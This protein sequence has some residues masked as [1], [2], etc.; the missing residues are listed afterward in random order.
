MPYGKVKQMLSALS[1]S[2]HRAL[3]IF[4]TVYL[5]FTVALAMVICISSFFLVRMGI[6]FFRFRGRHPVLCPETGKTAVIRIDA[7]HAAVSSLLADPELRVSDARF[8]PSARAAIKRV[9][10]S[11]ESL[12]R[13]SH[14]ISR[15]L[16][17][18]TIQTREWRWSAHTEDLTLVHNP[19]RT[20]QSW[21]PRRSPALQAHRFSGLSK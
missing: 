9:Y 10:E 16:T 6:E 3:V 19:V 13:V 8:G 2:V 12:N 1:S 17:Q 15:D 7:R 11:F 18:S 21:T 4:G 14:I 5:I 20:Q